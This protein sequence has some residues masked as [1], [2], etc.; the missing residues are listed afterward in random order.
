MYEKKTLNHYACTNTINIQSRTS[1]KNEAWKFN[2][3]GKTWGRIMPTKQFM[4]WLLDGDV[5][6]Q[7]SCNAFF[8]KNIPP[9]KIY[10]FILFGF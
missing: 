1:Y 4:N 2:E 10:F 7:D 6:I 3:R 5:T 9:F 8:G